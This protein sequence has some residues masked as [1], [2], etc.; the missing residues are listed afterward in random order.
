MFNPTTIDEACVQ[1]MHIE[2]KGKSAH[3]NFS[4]AKSSESKEGKEKE[5]GKHIATMRKVDERSTCSHC[6]NQGT[7]KKS[8]GYYI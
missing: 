5:K 1:A 6:Q 2:S 7:K 4:S 3:D 8:V